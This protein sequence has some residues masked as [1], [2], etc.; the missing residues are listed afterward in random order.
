MLV[1]SRKCQSE[2]RIGPDITVKVLEIRKGQIKLGIE[3]PSGLAVLRGELLPISSRGDP[4]LEEDLLE[5][6]SRPAM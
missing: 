1:L 3:A 5:A 2:I 4:H 6:V